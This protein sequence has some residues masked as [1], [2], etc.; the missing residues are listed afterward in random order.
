MFIITCPHC[1][2]KVLIE[3]VN[4]GIF[5]HAVFKSSGD[6]VPPHLPENECLKLIEADA[7]VGCCKPFRLLLR[8]NGVYE[9]VQCGYI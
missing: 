8:E 4:C 2:E 1:Q 5:R 6:Q 3:Q 9:A 7:V